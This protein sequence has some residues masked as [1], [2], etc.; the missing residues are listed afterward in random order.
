M[1]RSLFVRLTCFAAVALAAHVVSAAAPPGQYKRFDVNATTICDQETGLRWARAVVP[2]TT[3]AGAQ[4][5][6]AAP[7]RL[8]TAKELLTLVDE[9]RHSEQRLGQ[10][11]N[12]AIDGA[13]FPDTPVDRAFWTQTRTAD[14]GILITVDFGSGETGTSKEAPGSENERYARCVQFVGRACP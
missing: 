14:L 13:A 3:F 12:I 5:A 8:P 2:P 1:K 11:V 6:C 4:T 9:D 7:R 10:E